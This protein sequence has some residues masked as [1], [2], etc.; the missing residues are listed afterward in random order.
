MKQMLETLGFSRAR[1]LMRPSDII[2]A[3]QNE[4]GPSNVLHEIHLQKQL[5]SLPKHTDCNK[6]CA[7]THYELNGVHTKQVPPSADTY[8]PS[9]SAGSTSLP[10]AVYGSM[11]IHSWENS[12]TSLCLNFLTCKM[13]LIVRTHR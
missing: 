7:K 8:N 10:C 4:H 3:G 2:P 5:K 1:L 11:W 13:G 6:I 12:L 9:Q